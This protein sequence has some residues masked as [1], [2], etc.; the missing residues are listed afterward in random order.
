MKMYKT[1]VVILSIMFIAACGKTE[2][3][4]DYSDPDTFIE[5]LTE[6]FEIAEEPGVTT[7]LV[8][9]RTAYLVGD[10]WIELDDDRNLFEMRFTSNKDGVEDFMD[11]LGVS[12]SEGFNDLEP[13]EQTEVLGDYTFLTV[14]R[15][16]EE[17]TQR[18][19]EDAEEQGEYF[20]ARED[21]N[22]HLYFFG[23]DEIDN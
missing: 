7:S 10:F 5:E 11:F 19:I 16:D 4:I 8:S 14:G 1:L 20:D 13:D 21:Y 2:R 17:R 18:L 23:E 6:Y 22:V 15:R 9:N 3:E 12:P